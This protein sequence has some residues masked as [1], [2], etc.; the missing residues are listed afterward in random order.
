[1][2]YPGGAICVAHS[3]SAIVIGWVGGRVG[4]QVPLYPIYR[5]HQVRLA[6]LPGFSFKIFK[7]A[8]M[9]VMVRFAKCRNP[10]ATP[11][12]VGH[13]RKRTR[14]KRT[15]A[16]SPLP[17]ARRYPLPS[18]DGV[19]FAVAFR[20]SMSLPRFGATSPPNP[21]RF[22]SRSRRPLLEALRYLRHGGAAFYFAERFRWPE[23][24]F[25]G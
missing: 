4:A 13:T 20:P 22:R 21:G 9:R 8:P 6:M 3:L 12:L 11:T 10:R 15:P 23:L 14:K 24:P 7:K 19:S 17:P 16:H 25:D 18:V 1:M 2:S 5:P